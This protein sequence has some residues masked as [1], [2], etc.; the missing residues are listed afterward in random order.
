[1]TL[2]PGS[3]AR[4][5]FAFTVSFH[6]IFPT[7]SIGLAMFLAIIEGLWLKTKDQLYLQIYRFWLGIFAMG[8]GIGV[9]TGIVLSFEFGLG[10][11]RFGQMAGPAIGPMIGLEV[12]TSF[13]L[14]AGFLGI[15]LFGLN[16]V[17][18]RLHFFAT[19]MVA[20]GTLLS[21]SW[22]LSA[23]SWM[24]TPDGVLVQNGHVIVTDWLK[25]IVNPTWPYRLPH[26][27]TAAYLTACFLV[28]GV[29]AWYLLRG[30]HEAFGR[31]TVSLGMAFATVLIAAQVF[32][33]DVLYGTMLQHQPAKM[34][35]A[36]GFWEKQSQSPAPYYWVIVPDQANQ[37]N[38][39]ALGIPYLGSLWLTHSL[40]G[41]VEGLKNTPPDRQ[42]QMGMV[43]YGFRVMYGI[44][45]IMFGLAVASLWLR[46]QGRLFSTR[47]FL[48]A[49][50]VMAPSGVFATLGGWYLAETGRQPWVIYGIL[51][52]TDAIS[53][54]P[55][56]VLLST[57][58]AFVCI[59]ALFMA[60][61]LFF[62]AR[63]IRRGPLMAPAQ[64]E[65]SGSLKPALKSSMMD[66][67]ATK[68]LAPA[69]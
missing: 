63:M 26:M 14:E 61:F 68:K 10:F 13:F 4:I 15:M 48:R 53:P 24:Q 2:D 46:W 27:L 59:Y 34:Q 47:W 54:V 32:L 18:P 22:I 57:L 65:A 16:R 8:F 40:D 35:A 39:F 50:V 69:E 36:E 23:N 31:R 49:L 66:D 67:P 3:L 37:R 64:A 45:I 30:E 25:V 60:A 19:C 51:R 43:F 29:G 7:M 42:P 62:T 38:R 12:L 17:G 41:R 28:A 1:M 55:A 21:A 33:G 9:V 5:Q 44:A 11:A 56:A 58:I 52:T 6:I 20:L